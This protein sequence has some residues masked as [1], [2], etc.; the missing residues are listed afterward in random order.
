MPRVRSSSSSQP[1][2]LRK[3]KVV[4][5]GTQNI[6]YDSHPP[7]LYVVQYLI[8]LSIIL[9]PGVGTLAC[10]SW[11]LC[12]RPWTDFF[13]ELDIGVTIHSYD[14]GAAMNDRFSWQHLL[15]EG[16][17]FLK[18]LQTFVDNQRVSLTS[19]FLLPSY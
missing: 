8:Y 13:A 14:H 5:E 3:L 18:S 7:K 11:S 1:T 9:V 15:D 16:A 17:E 10:D 6:Q 19:L 2:S 12:D 4:K